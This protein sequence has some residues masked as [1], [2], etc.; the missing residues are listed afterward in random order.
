M[1]AVRSVEGIRFL[2]DEPGRFYLGPTHEEAF[3]RLLYLWE[4]RRRIGLVIGPSGSGKTAL[5][6]YF[7]RYVRRQGAPAAW[8]NLVG[9]EACEVP[10]RIAADFAVGIDPVTPLPVAWQ[11]LEDRLIA[12]SYEH[13]PTVILFDDADQAST[14]VVEQLN[15]LVNAARAIDYLTVVFAGR[16]EQVGR[17]GRRLLEAVDLRIDLPPWN[18]EETTELVRKVLAEEGGEDTRFSD[19]AIDRLHSIARGLPRRIRHL[20]EMAILA[21]RG[22]GIRMIDSETIELVHEELGLIDG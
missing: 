20:T 14:Q 5:L 4:R 11:I 3:S 12:F 15:R 16:L 1:S 13:A 10:A 21:A 9:V 17:L 7:V 22:R 6:E 18:V 8:I 2:R 19:E